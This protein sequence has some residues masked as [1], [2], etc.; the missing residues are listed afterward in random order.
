MSLKKIQVILVFL[1]FAS[2]V[3]AQDYSLYSG[4]FYELGENQEKIEF[5]FFN[6]TYSICEN[7][8]KSVPILVANNAN[9]DD[10]YSLSA[11]GAG[12]AVIG[13][14]E[15]SL[16]KRQSSVV[17]LE[18]APPANTRGKYSIGVDSFSSNNARKGL[19]LDVDVR[20]CYSLRLEL[21]EEDKACGGII[22]L[23]EGEITNDGEQKIDVDLGLNAPNWASLGHNSFSIAPNGTENFELAADIPAGAKGIFN[24]F[25]SASARNFPS[26]KSEKKLSIEAVPKYDCYRADIISDSKI[27]TSYSNAYIP[28]QIRNGGIKQAQY[29]ISLEAPSWISIEPKR[30]TVN[31]GQLGNVNLNMSPGSEIAEGK[32]QVKIYAK[33]SDAV[34]SKNIEVKLSKNRFLKGLKSFFAFYLYYIYAIL[35]VLAVLLIF[36]KQISGKIRAL[37]KT[38][39]TKKARLKSLE[40]A[41]KA[42]ETN[43]QLRHLE[44][45][46]FQVEK[47]EKQGCN[48]LI[49]F[50]IGLVIAVLALSFSAYHFDFPVSKEFIRGYYLYFIAGFLISVFIIFLIEFYRPLFKLLGKL[51]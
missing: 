28:V 15:F 45:A 34:Y 1:F 9:T 39:R 14:K 42:R 25:L 24:V 3:Y 36:R 43:R 31:P 17:F 32:Y 6:G 37:Y 51:K 20:K 12:W 21:Q 38:Y 7:E 40:A 50:F 2:F 35:A 23:Y 16:P 5:E 48:K 4:N 8:R 22:R 41:R 27:E 26:L 19:I 13:V 29:E 46:G 44:K 11:F 47:T 18:L 30:L 33:F 49:L 10:R